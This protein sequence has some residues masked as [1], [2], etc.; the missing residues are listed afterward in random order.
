MQTIWGFD[1]G[2]TSVGWAL[3]RQGDGSGEVVAM[4]VRI[5]PETREKETNGSAGA[6]LNAVRRQKRLMRRTLRRKRW[7]R[8][9][10]REALT[11]AGLLPPEATSR[12]HP[13]RQPPPGQDPYEIRA[14]GLIEPLTPHEIGWALLHLMKR[15]GYQGSRKRDVEEKAPAKETDDETK[16]TAKRD[17]LAKE[18]ACIEA[19]EPGRGTLGRALALR[20]DAYEKLAKANP[21][22]F[23]DPP[24]LRDAAQGREM[25]AGEFDRL[26]QVQAGHHP[27]LLTPALRETIEEIAL[28]Q[29]P[30]FFRSRTV[31][32]C[33]LEPQHD[34]ALKADWLTQRFE[35]LALVNGLRFDHGNRPPLDPDQR[36]IAI[37]YLDG[38]WVGDT[39]KPTWAGLR[40]AL[41]LTKRSDPRFTHERGQKETIRGNATE[42][43]LRAALG[44]AWTGLDQATRA[45]V[46]A[47]IGDAVR[48]AE[49]RPVKAEGLWEIR[50][51][52][53]MEKQRAQLAERAQRELG[54]PPSTAK[55]LSEIELADGFGRHARVTMEK[56]LP[57]LEAGDPY[58]TAVEKVYGARRES[59]APLAKL[60]G[61]NPSE[62]M[63]IADRFVQE[64]M[65]ALLAGIRNPTVLRTLGELQKVVNTLLRVHGRPDA[66]RLEFA[67][68]LKQSKD[69]RTEID[70]KQRKREKARKDAATEV[71]KLLD[72]SADDEM[73]LRYLLWKEQGG[74]S[75]YSGQN[76]GCADALNAGA[77]EIDHIFPV[78]RS[79]DD[80]QAN[81][82]LCFIGENRGPK[83]KGRRTPFEWLSPDA[84]RWVHLTGVV[85][86]NMAK[87]GWPG[88]DPRHKRPVGKYARCLREK[89]EE[90]QDAE[91]T[92]RQLTD[93]A[94]IA[95]AA[96][97]YL[98]LLWGGGQDGIN[99][100]QPVSGRATGLLRRAW[101]I[102]LS[103]LLHGELGE[104]AKVRDDH[105]HHA[106][107]ALCVALCDA[108]AVNA[109]SRWW[110][111]R[112][113]TGVRPGFALPWE[114]FREQ[115]K[116]AV[117]AIVVSHRVQAKLSGPLHEETRLGDTGDL[118]E[119]FRVYVKR[120]PITALSASEILGTRDASLADPGIKRAILA[121]LA[122]QGITDLKAA[123]P[124]D[125]ATALAADIRM[126]TTR[127]KYA[128]GPGPVIRRVRVRVKRKEGVMPV[129]AKRNMHAELGPGSN[130]HIAIYCDGPTVRFLVVTRRE[131]AARVMRKPSLPAVAPVHPLGGELVMALHPSDVVHR[132]VGDR[133][134]LLLIRF[135][136][137]AGPIFFKPLTMSG[138]PE[139]QVSKT[140]P[141]WVREGWRKVSVDPIGRIRPAK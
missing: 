75:P 106:V 22:A 135:A 11:E 53:D 84:D 58:T 140:P 1:L 105:R 41:G 42:G 103:R 18:I 136:Y 61:P 114:E 55:A 127:E 109:L 43:A 93:T 132:K 101:G 85:W 104:D 59:I 45:K 117:E 78:S 17:A 99:R 10:L 134:E 7:R 130:H 13:A 37:T 8:V 54:L 68:D 66:I 129:H 72:R 2:V 133:N 89:L 71:A 77:T 31:G 70:A 39:E 91:F 9:K 97:G 90:A 35:M 65:E 15:R 64:R 56:L 116:S 79:F 12:E 122:S 125:L 27:A 110:Q 102:G 49:Y 6:P 76:I 126:P 47:M 113:S 73:I 34:R 96:R 69:E 21:S 141:T 94:F 46:R 137:G 25:V 32:K 87:S 95:K 51:K 57:H 74:I 19:T 62:V 29:R 131:A 28:A 139:K 119:G 107:D 112:E 121:H 23:T 124:K 82:V 60:P 100:V 20:R 63:Q 36:E 5:F 30:T 115:T 118:D 123:K 120:K 44:P 4:G 48:R 16:A 26:W 81:K 92:N 88:L 67:R 33:T 80:S 14:R 24:R 138:N 108:G 52:Q 111:V 38:G 98:G 86:P 128:G 50:D 40:K 3:I 83:G